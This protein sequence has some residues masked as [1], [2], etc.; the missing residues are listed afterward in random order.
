M[1][2]HEFSFANPGVHDIVAV[3]GNK[4][5]TVKFVGLGQFV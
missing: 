3:V 1:T 4:L 5:V 2:V